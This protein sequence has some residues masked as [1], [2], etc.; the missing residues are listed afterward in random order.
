MAD[1]RI[2]D[3]KDPLRL[4]AVNTNAEDTIFVDNIRYSS[5]DV[6]PF[7]LALIGFKEDVIVARGV[8]NF[9]LPVRSYGN[10]LILENLLDSFREKVDSKTN[11]LPFAAFIPYS[12]IG[13][14]SPI[15]YPNTVFEEAKTRIGESFGGALGGWGI[16]LTREYKEQQITNKSIV[17]D[18]TERGQRVR[19]FYYRSSGAASEV[20]NPHANGMILEWPKSVIKAYTLF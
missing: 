2:G 9:P 17:L 19:V 20:L 1:I 3:S 14:R 7:G 8:A 10:R 5:S 6:M 4:F 15:V 16:E 12:F 11:V 13:P 18:N